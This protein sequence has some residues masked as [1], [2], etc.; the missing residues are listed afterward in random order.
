MRIR[1]RV[2]LGPAR[3]SACALIHLKRIERLDLVSLR[4]NPTRGGQ[5]K[6]LSRAVSLVQLIGQKESGPHGSSTIQDGLAGSI[7]TWLAKQ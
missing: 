4:C 2:Q 7:G 1:N 6:H 3:S 5:S